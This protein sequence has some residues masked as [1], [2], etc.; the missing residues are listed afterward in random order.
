M[1]TAVMN[2]GRGKVRKGGGVRTFSIK[3]GLRGEM[4]YAIMRIVL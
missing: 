4:V 2:D 3:F 1:V